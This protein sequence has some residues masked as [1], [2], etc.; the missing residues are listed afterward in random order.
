MRK[1]SDT[2][3][4]PR[5][6]ESKPEVRDAKT[7]PGAREPEV[8]PDAMTPEPA[9]RNAE[10]QPGARYAKTQPGAREPE[11]RP[12][13]MTPEPAARD[14][15]AQPGARY[16]EAQPGA[17]REQAEEG[18]GG[19]GRREVCYLRRHAWAVGRLLCG[20]GRWRYSERCAARCRCSLRCWPFGALASSSTEHSAAGNKGGE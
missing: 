16:A 6:P 5:G 20:A 11:V 18:R 10:A 1:R 3:P 9:A 12:D 8:R 19:R 13:A 2:D 14:A 4:A 15:E 17:I 7:Q